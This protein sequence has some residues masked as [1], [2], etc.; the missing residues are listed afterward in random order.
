MNVQSFSERVSR[1]Q[2][3]TFNLLLKGVGIHDAVQAGWGLPPGSLHLRE[4]NL[5]L[6]GTPCDAPLFRRAMDEA[7][8]ATGADI[9]LGHHALGW[10]ALDPA[11]FSVIVHM[12]REL[13]LFE[14]MVLYTHPTGGHWLIPSG[15]GPFIA[16][17]IGG[18]RVALEPPF[19]TFHQRC[20]GIEAACTA[21]ASAAPVHEAA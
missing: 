18:L 13:F 21:L 11:E 17:E 9:V 14:R 15:S 8:A 19:D 6:A 4:R 10:G 16:L 3:R 20:A 7:A 5:I 12:S 2:R 1:V